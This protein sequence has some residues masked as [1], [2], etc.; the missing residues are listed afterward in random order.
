MLY[1]RP[2]V[3]YSYML[4]CLDLTSRCQSL[5]VVQVVPVDAR[6]DKKLRQAA[7]LTPAAKQH[8]YLMRHSAPLTTTD[9]HSTAHST[10]TW[11]QNQIKEAAYSTVRW[12]SR[13]EVWPV[14]CF[15]GGSRCDAVS[16]QLGGV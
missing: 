3:H 2:N 14:N 15:T 8:F 7:F 5:P 10:A 11:Y 6:A 13:L 4:E 16:D 1:V 12:R 9:R